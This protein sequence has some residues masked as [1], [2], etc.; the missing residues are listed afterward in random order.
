MLSDRKWLGLIAWIVLSLSAGYSGSLFSPGEW[1]QTLEKPYLTP[2]DLVF[3]IVWNLLY[4]LMGTA[5]WCVWNSQ[6]AFR[7]VAILLFIIQ[8]L[9]N[10]LWSYL[11]FGMQSPGL[12]LL[13]IVV[14]WVVLLATLFVFYN[15]D[16]S[17]GLL[18]L[19]YIAWVTFAIYLNY[20]IYVLN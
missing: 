14:L 10:V 6:S 15:I 7:P 17:A 2:P 11:F 19:P 13:E 1:Y 5:A 9:L 4:I 18:F 3:P 12:A 16:T 20:S 8:L